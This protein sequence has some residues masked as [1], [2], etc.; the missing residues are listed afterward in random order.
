METKHTLL[1]L[2]ITDDY[3]KAK[4]LGDSLASE[5]ESKDKE[6]YDLKH[7]LIAAQIKAVTDPIA[8]KSHEHANKALL[9]TYTQT[10]TNLADAVAKKHSHAN[11]TELAKFADG[12]KAKIDTAVQSITAG[13]GLKA[14]KTGT[15]VAVDFDDAVTF[16]FDCGTSAE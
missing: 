3:F 9:D 16:V 15:N 5:I 6:I 14:T 1:S 8:A 2:N 4:K 12:D 13:T 7:E 10:E 11:A